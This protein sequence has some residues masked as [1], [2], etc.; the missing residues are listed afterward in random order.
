VG[1]KGFSA[2]QTKVVRFLSGRGSVMAWDISKVSA[3][4]MNYNDNQACLPMCTNRISQIDY[5]CFHSFQVHWT[6]AFK[7]HPH[8]EPGLEPPWPCRDDALSP[9]GCNVRET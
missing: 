1:L 9:N 6:N 2:K 5:V 3:N 8:P 7:G 4:Q